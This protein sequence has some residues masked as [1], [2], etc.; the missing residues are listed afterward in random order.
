MDAIKGGNEMVKR[1]WLSLVLAVAM[2]VTMFM[3]VTVVSAEQDTSGTAEAA[4]GVTTLTVD[5]NAAT[6]D[7]TFNTIRDAVAKAAAINPQSEADRVII[8][9][10][11]GD[12]EEQIVFDNVKYI[13]LQQTPGTS[14]QVDLHW[15]Y[16]TGYSAANVDLNGD[17][18]PDIDWSL[19]ETWNGYNS[20]DEKFTRYEIGQL[21]SG[22]STISYYDKNGVA[23]K[24]TAVKVTNLGNSGGMSQMAAL[25]V[26]SNSTDIT[27]KDFN[28]VNSVPVM[29]TQGE[30]DAHLTPNEDFPDLPDRSGLTVCDE[31][32][33][34]EVPTDVLTNGTVDL[35]KYKSLVAS[36][37]VFTAGESAY[38]AR[39]SGFNE[40][41]HAISINGDR[42]ILENVR[43]RGNQDSVYI[44]TGRIYF[45]NCD[46]IG[47][48]DYIYGNATAVFDSCLLGA[49]GMSDKDYGATITAANHDAANPYGYLFFNCE[50]YNVRDNITNSLYGRP[51]RQEAQIT[52]YNTLIDDTAETGLSKAGI[53]AAGWRDMSGS[54]AKNAR[55][56]EYGTT[57]KS[58]KAIDFSGRIVNENAG[59]GT[60]LDEWQI[61]E[62]NPRNYFTNTYWTETK[63]MSEWDPMNFGEEYLSVVDSEIA[64]SSIT[65][66]SGEDTTITLPTPS[67]SNIEFHWVSASTNAVVSSDEKTIEVVRP[68][69]GEEPIE[70]SVIL[71]AKDKTTG[72]GDKK[73][74]PVTIAATT[75][76]TNVFN[77]PV[78]LEQSTT[79][80][81]NYTVTITKNG[82]LI[83]Q[84][85]ISVPSGS[86]KV[87]TVIEN[88]PASAGGID[89]DIKIVSES[90]NFTVISPE[91]GTISVTGVTGNDVELAITS[92]R[93]VDKNIDI[94]TTAKAADGNKTYDL[95]ALAKANGAS[96]FIDTSDEISIEFDLAVNSALSAASYI[97][98]SA[99]TPNNGNGAVTDRFTIIKMNNSWHQLDA[100]DNTQGFSGSSNGDHQLLN[101]T[102]KYQNIYP[103]NNHVKVTIDY[104][105][106]TVTID[107]DNNGGSGKSTT[108]KT[109]YAFPEGAE[110]GTINMG[111][112]VGKTTDDLTL[113]NVVVTYKEVLSGDEP[114]PTPEPT[115]DPGI[116]GY[117]TI[118]NN[119]DGSKTLYFGEQSI[120]QS[121]S[122][123]K[124]VNDSVNGVSILRPDY[125]YPGSNGYGELT[126]AEVD[127]SNTDYDKV[128]VVLSNQ[129]TS[130]IVIKVGG[131]EVASLTDVTTGGW[132]PFGTFTADLS[133]TDVSGNVTI[134][135]TV[136]SGLFCGNFAYLRFYNSNPS[137]PTPEPTTKPTPEP[138]GDAV[139]TIN[140][141]YFDDFGNL[142][143]DY[144]ST[145]EVS[146]AELF[147]AT[148]ADSSE[149]VLTNF[150]K[151]EIA[152]EGKD[153]FTY[154]KPEDG[155]TKLFIWDGTD[156][157]TPLSE[158]KK[159][160]AKNTEGYA[161]DFTT[162]SSVP[163]YSAA[164]G[165]GFVEK[166]DAIM[167][168]G[169][170][171]QVAPVSEITLSSEG[172]SVTE[173]NGSYLN[174][175]NSNQ[176][177]YG[178]MIY[179]IDTGSAGAY[180]LEV[181]V[182]GT[183]SNTRVAPTGMDSSRLTGT[184]N[185][186]NAGLAPRTVSASWSDST[187]SYDF[188]TGEDF[189][190][191]EVEPATLPTS[192]A[193]QTVGIKSIKVTPLENNPA[194]DKPTIH[195]LG[196]S[197]QK[198]YTF[199]E[200]ISS[201]GQTI[202]NYFDLD[203]VNIINYS[204]GGRAMKSNYNEGRLDEVLIAGKE[205]DY[206]FIH[207]AHNDE[208]V[209]NDRFER[210]AATGSDLAANNA[211]YNKWLNMYV[212][213]IKARGMIP[214]LVTAM[215]RTSSG[216]VS[217]S[218]S[219]PNGFNPDSPGNMRTKAAS[220][221]EVGLI[222][223]FAGAV[224]YINS[225]DSK[226]VIYLY[227]GVEAGELPASNSANGAS[228]SGT[229]YKEAASKQWCRIMLQSIYDQS[230]ASTDTYTDKSIMQG[231]VSLL[232]ESVKNAAAT[233]DWSAVF[234]EMASDVSAVG[235]VPGA[236]KQA[237]SNYYY[238]NNIEKVLQLGL[239]H[240][241]SNNLFKPNDAM[242][243]G[244]FARAVEKAFG[245][246]ENSLTNY[247]KTYE[248]LQAAGAVEL[249]A[250][251]A[252]AA[253]E[254][255][256]EAIAA[257][258]EYT[259]TVNQPEGGS[260]IVYNESQHSYQTGDVPSG[261]TANQVL[262]D[263]DYFTMTAPAT[264]TAGSD[265]SGTFKDNEN[266]SKNYIEFRNSNPEKIVT[267]TAKESGTLTVYCRAA[268]NKPIEL[269]ADGSSA[270]SF[271][272]NDGLE[273][274]ST[275]NVYGTVHFTVKEGVTYSLYT[276]GGTGRLF[277]VMFEAAYPQS[278]TA[279]AANAGDQIKIVANADSGYV[280]GSI[281][282]NGQSVSV[283]KEYTTTVNSDI[284]VS[285]EFTKEPEVISETLIAS[286]AA[287]TREAMGAILYDAYLAAY[288]KNADGTW[289]KVAYMNQNGSV[290]S[291]DDPNYDPN[292]QYEGTPYIP[293]TGWGAL[294]DTDSLNISLYAKVK[295]A[296]NL[297][298]IRS[299]Q[300]ISR[301]SIAVGTELEPTAVV[302]RAKAAKTLM[303]AFTLTQP[304]GNAS[305]LLPDGI[306]HASE[307]ADIAV[308]NPNA[309]STPMSIN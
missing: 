157:I 236:V 65:V 269:A 116:K 140:E 244:E 111:W 9:V 96:D 182:T 217:T 233:G 224:D 291:P 95:I 33:A 270:Q 56:F 43:A 300:G 47:G 129:G 272:V 72:Y 212:E 36:G 13:T 97:D 112:F 117:G 232:P 229:H 190:E 151:F 39:S 2:L 101:I 303:F 44:S 15:Y 279:L 223:L 106:Q 168:S 141:A 215:P 239:L 283:S 249:Q 296:Y 267:Y 307:T 191:I 295:E 104:K 69:A 31:S 286:D 254:E 54:E 247:T 24:N 89:Y 46:L 64:A 16:C 107:G 68:A 220:D 194:G 258:D 183:S 226:E 78:T 195:I 277:G 160:E 284:T 275:D 237:E 248:E 234:P 281:L 88:I 103:A 276:R 204:M 245:L 309:P 131:T 17:Y 256:V 201:W 218:S 48:T 211:N 250:E 197:T 153:T 25:V 306:N 5:Q 208:T 40:R 113:S 63:N 135:S 207:S 86:G 128:E 222:E 20:G 150:D 93:L 299:E 4:A 98:F 77:I 80:A 57:N 120:T 170:E 145:G 34:E 143:V 10:N 118:T 81:N 154:Q 35:A 122:A 271:Y 203:K 124:I 158:V 105:A 52:F 255:T 87:S 14:G 177:N 289:N 273:A 134:E 61:L 178:G 163:V 199:N 287:L 290:P 257:A 304:T 216:R 26:K 30:K 6:S 180:H 171:R 123:A 76:T 115:E 147:V 114:E 268:G 219:K 67:N 266:I 252:E 126:M 119:S 84:Q 297:G 230:V 146:G 169:Y 21:L 100:V 193:P 240:K 109:F 161:I 301:G 132:S 206:V 82:A 59:M 85:V 308:P 49:E 209:S 198:T 164:A 251:T 165:Q 133:T 231:L 210:G 302:T 91:D 55:F 1:R 155:V 214:V 73:E 156:N 41:G 187:W 241:D 23:H 38:L 166:S 238:R 278:D 181:E 74:I 51:W 7:T 53:G 37:R 144:S 92:Q 246:A 3:G 184:S 293:L 264:I 70:S 66:P 263:N 282:V 136:T 185:W 60:V 94:N 225:L 90:N 242:T 121:T 130:D 235:V 62:F 8:N 22:V 179:R 75:D 18:N 27:V 11:P 192:S 127:L 294:T 32:T 71:Y 125:F 12:Y 200:N 188:A 280:I 205:G 228:S 173:S 19:D 174:S 175:T 159:V 45:K 227:E 50:F 99:G 42:I 292:I 265:N 172:A 221:S 79:S 108:P 176:Y 167:P 148:Y 139:Y 288:G 162:L 58:G 305:Q 262:S 274:G 149:Q 28:I 83:K 189:I 110:K 243:V 253:S 261:V 202:E 213:A 152:A 29:V 285:A 138:V 137:T 186:D 259:V 196:D 102:G 260:V 298:L 142:Y